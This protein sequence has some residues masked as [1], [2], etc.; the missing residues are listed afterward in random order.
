MSPILE[1]L[2]SLYPKALTGSLKL[3]P[4]QHSDREELSRFFRRLPLEERRLLKDDVTDPAVIEEFFRK[5]DFDKVL[6]L[7]AVEGERIVA[8]ATLHRDRRGWARHVARIRLTI[9]PEYRHMGLG[10][11]LISEFLRIAPKL[12][13]AYLDAEVLAP[14][15]EAVRLFENL[16]FECVAT[17]PQ[18]A[19]DLAGN[20]H[21]LLVFSFSVMPAARLMPG[22]AL[23]EEEAD[24]GGG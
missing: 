20:V 12:G 10:H 5:L 16:G 8:D 4:L 15:A 1:A 22:A 19:F 2:L 23:R 14:Q 6:P 18:H 11:A 24:V 3:R 9:D 17:F 7:L 21:D 13:I